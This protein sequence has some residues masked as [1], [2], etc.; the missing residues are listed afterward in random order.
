MSTASKDIDATASRFHIPIGASARCDDRRGSKVTEALK[1]PPLEP[2]LASPRA[3]PAYQHIYNSQ[4][5]E[6]YSRERDY[7]GIHSQPH[8][9]YLDK[10]G[11]PL[12]QHQT[13]VSAAAPQVGPAGI[14]DDLESE[15]TSFGKKTGAPPQTYVH[16]LMQNQSEITVQNLTREALTERRAKYQAALGGTIDRHLA[17]NL[18]RLREEAKGIIGGEGRSPREGSCANS[19]GDDTNLETSCRQ[20][21]VSA[22]VTATTVVLGSGEDL[23]M[24]PTAFE[25]RRLHLQQSP[26]LRSVKAV[27]ERKRKQVT[28][29]TSTKRIVE[30]LADGV[31]D[32]PRRTEQKA[33]T[34]A[35][36]DVDKWKIKM[37]LLGPTAL[38]D[39]YTMP[40]VKDSCL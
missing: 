15:Y 36:T 24:E 19:R 4:N 21:S 16:Q 13:L 12:V 3:R 11:K 33:R 34:S 1:L 8:R 9:H 22:N 30:P 14:D 38:C 17:D 25:V 31:A 6:Y 28:V 40:D 39:T 32:P 7:H 27:A 10:W 2:P 5:H 18:K 20:L 35:Y 23:L 29:L 37:G 26:P